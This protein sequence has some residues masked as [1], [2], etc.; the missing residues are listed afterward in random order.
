[1][2]QLS[3]ILDVIHRQAQEEADEIMHK[4]MQRIVEIQHTFA[5]EARL[6]GQAILNTASRQADEIEKRGKSQ[7]DMQERNIQLAARR[8]LLDRVFAEVGRKLA[9]SDMET[10][11]V[12]YEN[13]IRKYC[14]GNKVIV[15]L[16]DDDR[17]MLGKKLK[18]KGVEI[19]LDKTAG[20]F[21]GGLIIKESRAETD[22]TFEALVSRM[23]KELEPDVAAMLFGK[24]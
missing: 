9:S 20:N 8:R 2:E 12:F 14:L 19:S 1:M 7:A 17:R 18:V 21:S 3:K 4:S 16:N 5:N 23:Q 24:L 13:L 15:Q 10:R 11:R 22:C 6:G